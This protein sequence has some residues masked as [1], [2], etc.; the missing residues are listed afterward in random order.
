M[1]RWRREREV[2]KRLHARY[3]KNPRKTLA[4][5]AALTALR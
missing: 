3:A 4:M 1:L 5:R 2:I